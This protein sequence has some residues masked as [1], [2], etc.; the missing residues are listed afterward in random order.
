MD[1][2]V[3]CDQIKD[4]Y[5]VIDPGEQMFYVFFFC[6]DIPTKHVTRV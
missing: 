3:S 5:S 6:T 4:V 1:I 2:M